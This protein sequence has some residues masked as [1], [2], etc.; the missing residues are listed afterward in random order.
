MSCLLI[1]WELLGFPIA[2][3]AS[4]GN[5]L[6][7]IGMELN[8]MPGC[9]E[10]H[11]PR[12]K[13][14]EIGRMAKEFSKETW[15]PTR[16]CAVSLGSAWTL[17]ESYTYGSHSSSSFTQHCIHRKPTVAHKIVHGPVRLGRVFYWHSL[18]RNMN[19][20]SQRGCGK[21]VNICTR[22]KR[23]SVLGI[24]HPGVLGLCYIKIAHLWNICS[25]NPR[26]SSRNFLNWKKVPPRRNNVWNLWEAWLLWEN[27]RRFGETNML[28][29]ASETTTLAPWYFWD[30][31]KPSQR[32]MQQLHAKRR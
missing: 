7:W 31:W 28:D 15:S 3:K 19:C 20:A 2:Y 24:R 29:Y 16:T 22:V 21:S 25:G 18:T 26:H 13:M 14:Q 10:V 27:G 12:E 5:R 11:I 23:S 1:G 32:A 6:K 8:I 9:V 30:S 4:S 17:Q